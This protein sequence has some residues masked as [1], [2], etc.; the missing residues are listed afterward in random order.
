MPRLHRLI[1]VLVFMGLTGCER[2]APP[3]EAAFVAQWM[4][5]QYA[6][7][8]A[9]R[10]NPPV[11]S[12]FSAYSAIALY[13]GV[14]AGS[15]TL[16][17]L[18]G[19]LNGLN[20][21]PAPAPGEKYDWQV[22][23]LAS[24]RTVLKDLL[25]EG[26]ASTKVAINQLADSQ[27][28]ARSALI[29]ESM[30]ARS[31]AYG[32]QLGQA[33]LA[34]AGT[35][36]FTG[37]RKLAYAIPKGAGLW[38]PTA[39]ETQHRSQSMSAQTDFVGDD[40]PKGKLKPGTATERSLAVNRPKP[41]DIQTIT[42]IDPYGAL[43]P[44]WDRL[45]PF[46]LTS[47]DS[48]APIAPVP[49]SEDRNS[50]FFRQAKAVLD[51]SKALTPEQKEIA[52]FWAD[53]PGATGTPVG[54]WLGVVSSVVPQRKLDADQT[55]EAFAL[56][57]IAMADGFISC[58]HWKYR[59]NLVRPITYVQKFMD[60]NWQTLLYT[61]PFPE[62]TSGHSVQSASAAEVL[63]K[64]LGE[65]AFEDRTHINLGH[66]PR[67]FA[68]FR[69]ASEEAAVSRIYGGIHYPMAIVNGVAQGRCIGK[70]VLARVKTRRESSRVSGS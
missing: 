25:K 59:Y 29:S 45:R 55:A 24:E 53:D 62:Y 65:V 9:E 34:W 15:T 31:L 56:A 43:E 58:W 28:T 21:L 68:S 47:L 38:V 69:A 19:Q 8:R 16:R 3:V 11:A 27:L 26:F 60:K 13:E 32:E 22:V 37:T 7:T 14:A 42:G 51:S 44:Y 40:D 57:S 1:P 50:D 41:A 54:H 6:L 46:V 10:L 63:T 48:C 2:S 39:V 49:Y 61:P 35:D 36:G 66:P 18:A 23:A 4:A 17:T 5:K 12:R 70:Q 30:K 64:L 67:H 33:I 20:A 52:Y